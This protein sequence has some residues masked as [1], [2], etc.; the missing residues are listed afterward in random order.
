MMEIPLKINRHK[1]ISIHKDW[2]FLAKRLFG[3]AET[4]RM[5]IKSTLEGDYEYLHPAP[6]LFQI[7]NPQ[8]TFVE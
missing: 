4:L 5:K 7:W 3:R 2:E 8:E 6:K 1:G